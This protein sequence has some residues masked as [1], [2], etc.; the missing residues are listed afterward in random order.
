MRQSAL[1][2][3]LTRLT[4]AVRVVHFPEHRPDSSPFPVR[5]SITSTVRKNGT[6]GIAADDVPNVRLIDYLGNVISPRAP[7]GKPMAIAL[8]DATGT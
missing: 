6:L 8:P 5:M 2:R 1:S 4:R 7:E 3:L